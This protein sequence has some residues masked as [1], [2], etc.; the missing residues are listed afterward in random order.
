MSKNFVPNIKK[1]INEVIPDTIATI[2]N[3]LRYAIIDML[4]F[5]EEW[6]GKVKLKKNSTLMDEI[7][8]SE[9]YKILR[10]NVKNVILEEVRSMPSIIKHKQEFISNIRDNIYYRIRD[11]IAEE[12]IEELSAEAMVIIRQDP[13]LNAVLVAQQII[14]ATESKNKK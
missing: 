8:E 11:D 2:K 9:E 13:A 1:I 10:D 14:K 3:N 4:G 12:L 7:A 5:E 6:A